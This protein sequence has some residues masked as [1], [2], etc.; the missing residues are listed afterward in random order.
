MLWSAATIPI[1]GQPEP[2]QWDRDGAAEADFLGLIAATDG[3]KC[4]LK[5]FVYRE[6]GFEDIVLSV[7]A[8]LVTS[9]L[10]ERS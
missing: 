1:G 3:V 7:G 10:N 8:D 4:R 9:S 2:S 5:G 6:S